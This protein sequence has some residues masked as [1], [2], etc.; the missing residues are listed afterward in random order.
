MLGRDTLRIYPASK[1]KEV[2]VQFAPT[3]C[4]WAERSER[5]TERGFLG[6]SPAQLEGQRLCRVQSLGLC[7]L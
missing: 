3:E 6:P 5:C 4:G 7:L 1:G 2:R